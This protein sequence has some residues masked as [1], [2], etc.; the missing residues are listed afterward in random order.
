VED[1]FLFI[2]GIMN[3]TAAG[4]AVV[5]GPDGSENKMSLWKV[6]TRVHFS[7]LSGEAKVPFDNEWTVVAADPATAV[8]KVYS[9]YSKDRANFQD[10]STQKDEWVLVTKV[11]ILGIEWL[12]SVD[13]TE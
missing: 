11:E 9:K 12:N 13:I 8:P 1:E 6:K 5:L 7:S 4:I 10:P 3:A 2:G